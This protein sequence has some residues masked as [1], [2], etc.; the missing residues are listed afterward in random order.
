MNARHYRVEEILRDGRR[1]TIRAVRADDVGR[2]A[3]AFAG[4]ERDSVYTRFFAFRGTPDTTE[5]AQ[6][7][8]IDFVREVMLVATFAGDDAEAIIGT[9]RYVVV[10]DADGMAAE[11]AFTVEEDWQ[12]RGV[13]GRLFA[14]LT[15]IA[16]ACGVARFVA[17][18]L[19]DNKAMLGVFTRSG[20][21]FSRER[22]DGVVHVTLDLARPAASDVTP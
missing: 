11:I 2:L 22:G 6:L 21:P 1:V 5:L 9:A 16:R 15:T 7:A 13:A 10:A 4:L 14:H 18:V 20:L 19:P 8:A 3:R 17:D 12:G